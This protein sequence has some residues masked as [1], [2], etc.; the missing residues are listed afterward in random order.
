M[1][2]THPTSAVLLFNPANAGRGNDEKF[3][4]RTNKLY[5]P[6]CQKNHDRNE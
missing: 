4:K 5:K 3:L 6:E 2:H 1:R